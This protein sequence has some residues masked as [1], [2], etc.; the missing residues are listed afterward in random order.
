MMA[1]TKG[2]ILGGVGLWSAVLGYIHVAQERAEHWNLILS[3]SL[4]ET[5]SPPGF[6]QWKAKMRQPWFTAP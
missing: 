3:R 6:R 5:G 1:G 4:V 2:F